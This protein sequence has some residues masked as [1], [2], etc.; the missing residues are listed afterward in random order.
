MHKMDIP[1]IIEFINAQSPET[2]IYIGVDSEKFRKQGRWVADYTL[3]VVVHI[4]SSHGCK[5]FG[6]VVREPVYDNRKERPALRL[7]SEVYKAAEL[8]LKLAD[9]LV[10]RHVE[11]HLDLNPDER[12]GS[13]CVV[14]QAIGYVRGTCG[15]TPMVKPRSWAASYAADRLKDILVLETHEN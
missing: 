3:A 6:E 8:Y 4:D 2:V 11:I 7:M 10:D 15:L 1:A 14:Q 13:S 5:I 12:H 9:A